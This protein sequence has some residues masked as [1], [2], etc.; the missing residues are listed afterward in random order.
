MPFIWPVDKVT[1]PRLDLMAAPGSE[2]KKK[3]KQCKCGP[4][5]VSC[6][7]T[8][9]QH[10]TRGAPMPDYG[11]INLPLA[12]SLALAG[13]IQPPPPPLSPGF[14][15]SPFLCMALPSPCMFYGFC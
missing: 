11:A 14:L 15:R 12:A 7:N 13:Y 6:A 8:F 3:K 2:E 10:L 9:C 1:N 4:D 5:S